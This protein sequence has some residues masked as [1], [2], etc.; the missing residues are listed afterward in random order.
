M[1]QYYKVDIRRLD[2]AELWRIS[3]GLGF[4]IA[5]F[6]KAFG[7]RLKV[8]TVIPYVNEIT[9]LKP[10]EVPGDV[11]TLFAA[12]LATWESLGFRLAFHFT[13][14]IQGEGTRSYA[15]ALL[16]QPG[17][18]VAQALYVEKK[19]DLS[20]RREGVSLCLSS[21]EDGTVM[22][23]SSARKRFN[24]PPEYDSVSM[25]GA[26]P[27]ALLRRHLR[28][29]ESCTHGRPV[30]FTADT[31]KAFVTRLNNRHVEFMAMRG[32]YTVVDAPDGPIG[33]R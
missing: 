32:V 33:P 5:A 1:L 26:P 19:T 21:F 29:V 8:D 31:L 24:T 7:I 17:T 11:R 4:V 13:V 9:V 12:P 2:Y 10:E 16:D 20:T 22:G 27:E 3:P 25:P 23:V 18:T 28:R 30:A 15:T 6:M 14:P